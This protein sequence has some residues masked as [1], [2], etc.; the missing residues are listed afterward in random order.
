M[1]T[2]LWYFFLL[3]GLAWFFLVAR[4]IRHF[5][6]VPGGSVGL[7]A[8][9]LMTM[10]F[11]YGGAFVYAMPGYTHLRPDGHWYLLGYGFTELMVLKA[12]LVSLLGVFGFALGCGALS[13][14]SR[15]SS[16]A[17][18]LPPALPQK[19]DLQAVMGVL[20]VLGLTGFMGQ[21]LHFR[22]EMSQALFET[23]RNVALAFLCTGFMVAVRQGQSYL[24][25]VVLA[26]LIPLYYLMVWGFVSYGFLV[27]MALLAF[28]MNQ[29]RPQ[30]RSQK[31]SLPGVILTIVLVYFL[32]FAFVAW[33]SF[34]DEIRH[35]VWEGGDGEVLEV[36]WRAIKETKLLSPWNFEALDLINI[37]LNLNIFIGRMMEQHELHPELHQNGATLIILPLVLLP[38][39]LWPDKPARGG[40]DFMEAHTGLS[41]SDSASFGTGSVFEFYIN[42]GYVG[43]FIGFLIMGL[44][45][46]R[47]DRAAAAHLRK[48]EFMLFARLYVVG[49]VAIDP[50][51]RPFFIV[52]GAVFAWIVMT[53]LRLAVT[54]RV[55]FVW[56]QGPT[57]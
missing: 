22:F 38:R 15:N 43:V 3:A 56:S 41:L 35:V 45:L 47:L 32:L 14:G 51:Q 8:A 40:S 9:L 11:L 4:T 26:A 28:W 19:R 16:A 24:R 31:F 44:V 50:M 13:F 39:F 49:V 53:F 2:N 29:L 5:Q 46:S 30:G 21:Y 36:M 18:A 6:T 17:M 10:S 48:G 54:K 37:R 55:R 20:G 1:N 57:R 33:F 42:F 52:N 27:G 34:R 25:W 23:F 12:T 7:P